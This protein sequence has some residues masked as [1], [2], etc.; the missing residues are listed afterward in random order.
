MVG[1]SER[2]RAQPLLE[3]STQQLLIEET[4]ANI[5]LWQKY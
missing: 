3:D 1:E 5:H 4:C 2:Q